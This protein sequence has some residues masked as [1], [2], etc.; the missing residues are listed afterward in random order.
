MGE[1]RHSDPG[2]EA[3]WRTIEQSP[4]FS[5]YISELYW[6]AA[7]VVRVAERVFEATAVGEDDGTDF[8]KVDAE[9]HGQL[10]LILGDAAKIRAL[11]GERP[12][13]RNQSAVAYGVQ[14]LRAKALRQLLAGVHLEA[15]L[16]AD[17]RHSL[18][19]FDER[20]DATAVRVL[21]GAAPLPLNVPFNM[22]V[23][24]RR[25]LLVLR[26]TSLLKPK[27]FLLRVYI[28]D[29]R[30]FVNAG[31]EVDIGAIY[32]ECAAIRDRLAPRVAEERD[33]SRGA[34]VLV[35][36]EESFARE[37]PEPAE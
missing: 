2:H 11:I 17:V 32:A 34:Y 36:T 5:I 33:D 4:L 26:G 9:L 3:F 13:R 1:P 20:L 8:I 21:E 37:E 30:M 18:E 24:R 22:V 7:N 35:L 25:G 14:A 16:S 31:E 29:E 12:K 19:H 15:T 23:S 6:L 27:L 10:C 28:A